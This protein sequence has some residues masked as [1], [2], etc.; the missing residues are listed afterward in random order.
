[1]LLLNGSTW[2]PLA[3]ITVPRAV[4][5]LLAGKAIAVEQSGK[6]LRSVRQQFPVPSV[7]ALRSYINVPRRRAHWSRKGVLIRDGY[8][9]IYCQAHPGTVKKG[10]MLHKG[11]FTVD[12]ITPRSKG[13]KDTW[14]NTACACY[15]CNH[16]KSD[17]LHHKAGMRLL[18][19]PKTPRTSYLVIAVGNGPDVWKRYIEY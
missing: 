2:E 12:H 15:Q 7:I 13:G 5:L 6:F 17:R 11:D 10:K 1:V 16:R 19:E 14:S 3:V 4:N 9:C 18:W 8:T